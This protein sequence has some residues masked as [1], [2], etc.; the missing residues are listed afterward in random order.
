MP[1][2]RLRVGHWLSSNG[3][4]RCLGFDS[5]HR[6]RLDGSRRCL[7]FGLGLPSWAKWILPGACRCLPL[8][9]TSR[10]SA[11]YCQLGK[12]VHPVRSAAAAA[13]PTQLRFTALAL[14]ESR[15]RLASVDG[16]RQHASRRELSCE[17]RFSP[18]ARS[19]NFE[20]ILLPGS[21]FDSVKAQVRGPA[22]VRR[23]SPAREQDSIG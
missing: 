15:I 8:P 2:P 20:K 3:I 5:S 12:L 22:R 6:A 13:S 1:I 7:G 4:S 19:K 21:R 10:G 18:I 9:S 14:P 23:S 17:A 16:P 11:V